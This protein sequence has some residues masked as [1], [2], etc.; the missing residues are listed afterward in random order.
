MAAA[1]ETTTH[2]A[3]GYMEQ[4]SSL[5]LAAVFRS[6]CEFLYWPQTPEFAIGWA[7]GPIPVMILAGLGLPLLRAPQ[8]LR[9]TSTSSLLSPSVANR[10]GDLTVQAAFWS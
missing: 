9:Q 5:S 6:W 4:P 1:Q 2:S 8:A 10:S 3:M 7:V